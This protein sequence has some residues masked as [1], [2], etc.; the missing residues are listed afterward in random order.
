MNFRNVLEIIVLITIWILFFNAACTQE[1]KVQPIKVFFDTDIAGD[2]DDVGAVA[3]LHSLSNSGE[4][5]I[6]GMAVSETGNGAKWGAPCL[7]AINTFYGRPNIP[8][9]MPSHG[10]RYD[11][12][13]YSKQI[14]EEFTYELDTI[15]D[16]TELYR[17]VLSEQ[18]DT[19]VVLVTVGYLT[20]ITNLLHSKP[21]KYSN[22]DGI[23]L[24][25][26]KVKKWVCMAGNFP[27]GGEECNASSNYPATKFA[28]A[29]WNRPILFVG[30]K[31]G[32]K[33]N[34]GMRLP[35]IKET[36]P[37]QRA[38]EIATCNGCCNTSFDQAT[39]L[40][41]VRN[42]QKYWN[43][44]SNGYAVTSNEHYKGVKWEEGKGKRH[45]YLTEKTPPAQLEDIIEDLMMDLPNTDKQSFFIMPLN[46]TIKV[47]KGK[48]FGY[49][50]PYYSYNKGKIS[51]EYNNLPEWVS[52][53]NDSIFGNVPLNVSN[54]IEFQTVLFVNN[55]PYDTIDIHLSLIDKSLLIE[56]VKLASKG[57]IS[58]SV[59][60]IKKGDK[61]YPDRFFKLNEI[62]KEYQD[63]TWISTPANDGHRYDLGDNFVTFSASTNVTVFVGYANEFLNEV[64]AWLKEWEKTQDIISDNTGNSFRIFKKSFPKGKIVLGN[65]TT[66][67]K[68][69][70]LMYLILVKKEML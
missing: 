10:F 49:R 54:N 64:P 34:T 20:N 57:C 45:S 70:R 66:E 22:L 65:N 26:K 44:V 2:H 21:D 25:N 29:N 17:K 5:E 53:S 30:Y 37:V 55:L 16:A 35:Y 48:Q 38:F 7:D 15:W 32:A 3:V 24:V 9:G 4:V 14:A 63:Y 23:E 59:G 47:V 39:V 56:N 13:V 18:P 8:I 11:E 61:L 50:L 36:N 12:I 1:H 6:L 40:A 19:S 27:E 43:I 33:I 51:I 42:P 60:K 28:I 52:F 69:I 31:I 41:A 67:D 46:N 68:S 62:P 58:V